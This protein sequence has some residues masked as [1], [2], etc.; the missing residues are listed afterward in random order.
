MIVV[1]ASVAA[2]W[3]LPEEGSA[4][5]MTLL[6]GSEQLIAPSLIKV[7]VLAA[8]TR[9]T[10]KKEL[11]AAEAKEDCEDWLADLGDDAVEL[12]P[13][14]DILGR[15]IELSLKIRH[16]LQDC[17]YLATAELHRAPLI[18]ADKPFFE[19]ASA[20]FPDVHFLL[21]WRIN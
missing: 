20:Q 2:K 11:T 4:E 7:E 16:P 13:E 9:R 8:I 14:A 21:K 18:T 6:G 3:Y 1:D 5:A 19:R 15:A 12:I 17:L 10:R